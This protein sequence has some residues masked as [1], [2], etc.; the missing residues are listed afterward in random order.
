VDRISTSAGDYGTL[1]AQAR[2]LH[3]AANVLSFRRFR[4]ARV[5]DA[6]LLVVDD[7]RV[8]GAHQRCLVRASEDLPLAA[9]IFLYIA[10]FAD[11]SSGCLDPAQEDALNHAAVKTLDD[12]AGI[13]ESGDFAWNVRVCKFTLSPANHGE[14][15]RFLR[16]MPDWFIGDLHR[17][18]CRDGYARMAP[19]TRAMSS[20]W[21][22]RQARHL[23]QAPGRPTRRP[24][25]R[26]PRPPVVSTASESYRIRLNHQS[27]DPTQNW[28]ICPSP[29]VQ[30][31]RQP[32]TI[33]RDVS[34]LMPAAP[35]LCQECDGR[36]QDTAAAVL[37]GSC[38][39]NQEESERHVSTSDVADLATKFRQATAELTIRD[40]SRVGLHQHLSD[41]AGRACR[42]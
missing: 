18:S 27:T 4:A 11:P 13:V 23:R 17:N 41:A 8:T 9:R 21:P 2:D 39:Q 15:S 5:R 35:P 30:Q 3:M 6:H 32:E 24:D 19:H 26:A 10:A 31:L 1:S 22:A 28:P 42:L 33:S 40:V 29:A 37:P 7:V 16:R 36:V 14:I 38:S 12:L 25:R 34:V 20:W